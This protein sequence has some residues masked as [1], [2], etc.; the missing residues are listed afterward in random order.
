MESLG[1]VS[2]RQLPGVAGWRGHPA[3]RPG[4]SAGAMLEKPGQRLSFG[5]SAQISTGRLRWEQQSSRWLGRR[6]GGVCVGCSPGVLG[7]W[8]GARVMA[9]CLSEG[10]VLPS[11]PCRAAGCCGSAMPP[12]TTP[13]APPTMHRTPS[14]VHRAPRA[15]H[16]AS[17]THPA[18]LPEEH[19]HHPCR[20]GAH[21]WT[22]K[23]QPAPPR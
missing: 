14:T 11:L 18:P 16:R 13:C 7:R 4:G 20:N 22:R 10:W 15:E 12:S 2:H 3:S 9:G 1:A 6:A 19:G 23:C 21:A 17:C 8:L 5:A